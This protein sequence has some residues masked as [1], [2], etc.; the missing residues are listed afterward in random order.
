MAAADH[1]NKQI[2]IVREEEGTIAWSKPIDSTTTTIKQHQEKIMLEK[3]IIDHRQSSTDS[4]GTLASTATTASSSSLSSQRSIGFGKLR[5]L[6]QL[7]GR[8]KEQSIIED[9][10][11]KN[12]T[13]RT[14]NLVV[15]SGPIGCGKTVVASSLKETVWNDGG[16]FVTWKFDNLNQLNSGD[17]F[18]EFFQDLCQQIHDAPYRDEIV[19]N[20]QKAG[21]DD[22]AILMDAFPS[23]HLLMGPKQS[24]VTALSVNAS[25]RHMHIMKVF[26]RAVCA[27]NQPLV[28]LLDDLHFCDGCAADLLSQLLGDKQNKGLM[29]VA[30]LNGDSL[31]D[32]PVTQKLVRDARI[33]VE[34][35]V[36]TNIKLR[37]LPQETVNLM[38]ADILHVPLDI[39]QPMTELVYHITKG[40][41]VFVVEVLRMMYQTGILKFEET[42]KTWTCEEENIGDIVQCRY[43]TCLVKKMIEHLPSQQLQEML[44]AAASLGSRLNEETLSV[45]LSAPVTMYLQAAEQK[46]LICSIDSNGNNYRFSHSAVQEAAYA[47]I[48][49]DERAAFHLAVGRKL[50]KDFSEDKLNRD[51]QCLAVMLGQLALG[52]SA[53]KNQK[54]RHSAAMLCLREVRL[55]IEWSMFPSAALAVDLGISLL[56][57]ESW[58]EEY[59]LTLMLYNAAAEIYYTIGDFAKVEEATQIVLSKAR[60]FCHQVQ[61]YSTKISVLNSRGKN[62]EAIELGLEVL[63]KLGETFPSKPNLLHVKKE[64]LRTKFQLRNKSVETMRRLP[65]MVDSKKVAAL[66]VLNVIFSTAY[67]EEPFL[68]PL[69]ATRMMQITIKHGLCAISSFAFAGWGMLLCSFSYEVQEGSRYGD[70]ALEMI[71]RYESREWLARV[72]CG[73]YGCIYT[74]S[75][76]LR[77][78]VC[79]V[80]RGYRVGLAT[81]DIEYAMLNSNIKIC[82]LFDLGEPLSSLKRDALIKMEE[83]DLKQQAGM[84]NMGKPLLCMIAAFMENGLETYDKMW[85]ELNCTCSS[86]YHVVWSHMHKMLIAYMFRDF[87]VAVAKS[88][89]CRLMSHAPFKSIDFLSFL[90]ISIL[91]EIE[92]YK[93]TRKGGQKMRIRVK[94]QIATM[95]KLSKVCPHFCLGKKLLL[96]GAFAEVTGKKNDIYVNYVG[97]INVFKSEGLLWEEALAN[98]LCGRYMFSRM[99]IAEAKEFLEK[100]LRLYNQ[101]GGTG[102]ATMLKDEM[103]KLFCN[104]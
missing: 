10:Y 54:E 40:N 67:V 90:T 41:A 52:K 58:R 99:Q 91:A 74:W 85:I 9:V 14:T 94:K 97:A 62:S 3:P 93:K 68:A 86:D 2:M 25:G 71:S 53:M 63:A 13:D 42:T 72:T 75:K 38:V 23:L 69:L 82:L 84:A 83:M 35:D 17:G 50:W 49:Q 37:E 43:V 24:N 59:D 28:I 81:G 92:Q 30:T 39:S 95:S 27:P 26:F 22:N 19:K 88:E 4:D 70:L 44:K 80:E 56:G 36:I 46:G 15:V 101:W 51:S 98:E 47:L 20:I 100:S 7:Y 1:E 61:A 33:N 79:P 29:F 21:P 89:L 77:R 8:Q 87:E 48:P 12:K 78:I 104:C 65:N 55:D 64:F 34:S 73:V 18:L 11:Y 5:E 60:I 96:K 76:P 31:E 32:H 45:V 57:E 102:K 6:K 103:D 66:R 16:M